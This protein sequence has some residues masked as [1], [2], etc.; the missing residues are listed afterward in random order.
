MTVLSELWRHAVFAGTVATTAIAAPADAG[1]T[2]RQSL[3]PGTQTIAAADATDVRIV[4]IDDGGYFDQQGRYVLDMMQEDYAY[5]AVRVE[6]MDGRPVENA[7]PVFS[8]DGSSQLLEPRDLAAQLTTNQDGKIEFAVIGGE[9]GLDRVAVEYGDARIEILINV[10]SLRATTFLSLVVEGED[11]LPW[12]T[13]M[14]ARIRYE[15]SGR[16]TEF[17]ALISERSGNTAR[18]SGFV[19]P[20]EVSMKHKHFLLT[21]HPPGCFFHTPGGDSG[22]VEVFADKGIEASSWEAIMLEGRFEALE[23]SDSAVYR[24]HDARIISR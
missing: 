8:I 20:L 12:D 13:L 5:I 4:P 21:S 7:E 6:A 23:K 10:I 14:Q 9:M 3:D 1:D 18:L 22:V 19:M 2:E 15:G 11:F 24:L 17:P 16:V